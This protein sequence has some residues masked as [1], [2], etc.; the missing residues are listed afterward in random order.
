MPKRGFCVPRRVIPSFEL[1]A[2]VS[3]P[4]F[5]AAPSVYQA[6][7]S[8]FTPLNW[9]T[10]PGISHPLNVWRNTWIY[11]SRPL[12]RLRLSSLNRANSS[13]SCAP[14]GITLWMPFDENLLGEFAKSFTF[15]FGNLAEPMLMHVTVRPDRSLSFEGRSGGILHNFLSNHAW[16]HRTTDCSS[17]LQRT[18]LLSSIL[19]LSLAHH[20]ER[21]RGQYRT[22]KYR[23]L[24]TS[25]QRRRIATVPD[26][27]HE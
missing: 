18:V 15:S 23:P 1:E 22:G 20:D 10:F 14:D 16:Q 17:F 27:C 2:C 6:E 12:D 11:P 8:G 5:N 25:K 21:T 9:T 26:G 24:R 19:S 13:Q 4:S 3:A 7:N